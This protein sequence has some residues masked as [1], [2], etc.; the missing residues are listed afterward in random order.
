M[1]AITTLLIFVASTI[2]SA[3]LWTAYW[4]WAAQRDPDPTTGGAYCA[5]WMLGLPLAVVVGVV[6]AWLFAAKGDKR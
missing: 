6:A 2:A 3:G 4:F 5:A 1:N